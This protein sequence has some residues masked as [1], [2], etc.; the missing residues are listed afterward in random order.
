VFCST[1]HKGY[2]YFDKRALE[3]DF[4][5]NE[6]EPLFLHFESETIYILFFE[7]KFSVSCWGNMETLNFSHVR[8]YVCSEEERF[9]AGKRDV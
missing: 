2:L 3:V 8:A 4:R 5:R 9:V 1:S 6:R 7:K